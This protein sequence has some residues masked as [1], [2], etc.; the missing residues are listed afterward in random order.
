MSTKVARVIWGRVSDFF[1]GEVTAAKLT[2][3]PVEELRT[4][5]LSG[6]KARYLHN[7]AEHELKGLLLTDRFDDL[8]D[9]EVIREV[10][11]I[12]GF[13]PWSADIFLMFHLMRPDV[14][15]VGDL[16]IREAVKR[17]YDLPERPDAAQLLEIA[18]RWRPHR[19]L[20][21]RYLWRSLDNEPVQ[22]EAGI[23]AT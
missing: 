3:A 20:V 22:P 5:G 21:C 7:L 2:T 15:P 11:A 18:E 13:G 17:I 14:M 10:T 9:E 4:L 23:V 8:P 1:D 12:K 16:G 19:T 6:A